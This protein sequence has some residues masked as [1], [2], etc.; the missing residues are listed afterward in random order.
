MAR[1]GERRGT[2]MLLAGTP[3]GKR[4]LGR[5]R[6]GWE[7]YIKMNHLTEI[8]WKGVECIYLSRYREK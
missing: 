2:Y 8:G 3:D 6:R 7:D 1:M 4:P 5:P